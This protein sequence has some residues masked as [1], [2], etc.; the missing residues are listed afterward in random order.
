MG[1]AVRSDGRDAI[2]DVPGGGCEGVVG[3][4]AGRYAGCLDSNLGQSRTPVG[5]MQGGK[6]SDMVDFQK[7]DTTRGLDDVDAGTD[8]EEREAE[9]E[10]TAD[11]EDATASALGIAIVTISETR[12]LDDDPSGDAIADAV[13]DAGHS[14][15]TR[16]LVRF[17]FD[18]IQKTIDV[19]TRRD[20][21]DLVV[22]TGGTDVDPHAVTVEAADP[23]LEQYLP[24]FGELFRRRLEDEI[25]ADA[26]LDRAAAG[27]ADGV[28]VACLPEGKRAATIGVEELLLPQAERLV[29]A[30]APQDSETEE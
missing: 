29:N 12:G 15:A 10:E 18:A 2:S 5:Y 28:P 22:T 8:D 6:R 11:A 16:E 21:V 26:I 30:G 20:D 7:R 23:L 17:E 14:V 3:N 13:T 25:G 4:T 27:I 1:V 9:S 24:G 19:L